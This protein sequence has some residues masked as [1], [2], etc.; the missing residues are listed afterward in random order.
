M[1]EGIGDKIHSYADGPVATRRGLQ[2]YPMELKATQ[3][4]NFTFCLKH[5][6]PAEVRE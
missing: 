2:R 4:R 5:F 6:F 3:R 1:V